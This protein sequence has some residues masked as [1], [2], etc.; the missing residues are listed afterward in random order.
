M[1][2]FFELACKCNN[3][4]GEKDFR[5]RKKLFRSNKLRYS[6][7]FLDEVYNRVNREY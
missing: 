1:W 5:D 7:L 3:L 6:I 4:G 2:C